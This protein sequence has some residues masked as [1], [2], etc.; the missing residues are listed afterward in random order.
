MPFLRSLL[1]R[2]KKN[3]TV[4]GM[5]GQMQGMATANSPPTKPM[6]RM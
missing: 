1:A 3:E 5:M 6:S 4:M 2:F